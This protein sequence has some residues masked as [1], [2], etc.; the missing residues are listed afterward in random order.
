MQ[1]VARNSLKSQLEQLHV[2]E[3]A[4][5]DS[6]HRALQ[7]VRGRTF[8]VILCGYEMKDGRTGQQFLEQGR[9]EGLIPHSKVFMMVTAHSIEEDVMAVAEWVPDDFIVRPFTPA[10]LYARLVEATTKKF[11]LREILGALDNNEL[12]QVIDRCQNYLDTNSLRHRRYVQRIE[13]E[14]YL[15][16]EENSKAAQCFE[17]I[18]SERVAPWAELGLGKALLRLGENDRAQRLLEHVAGTSRHHVDSLDSLA[19]M[20]ENA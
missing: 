18:L 20:Y 9:V 15:R 14:T 1:D 11:E 13:A 4:S 19:R 5:V 7:A 8:D 16:M 12:Q 3:V 2:K 6:I 10:T 17:E